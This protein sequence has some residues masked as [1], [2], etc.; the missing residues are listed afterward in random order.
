MSAY[1]TIRDA[2]ETISLSH[3][4]LVLLCKDI[5]IISNEITNGLLSVVV[6]LLHDYEDLFLD[7]IPNGLPPKR[8]I[9]H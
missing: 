8:G 3:P 6:D 2:R 4:L 9:E 1:T 5:F 7:E